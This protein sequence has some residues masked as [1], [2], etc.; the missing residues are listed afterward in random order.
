M[1]GGGRE[2]EEQKRGV[3]LIILDYIYQM[4]I[5]TVVM[6]AI[7]LSVHNIPNFLVQGYK[8]CAVE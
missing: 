2:G 5:N 3:C 6:A 8:I 4:T 1:G 7:I